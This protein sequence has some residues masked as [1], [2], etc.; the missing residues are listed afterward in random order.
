MV[1]RWTRSEL[2][3][4]VAEWRRQFRGDAV[5]KDDIDI[6]E[7]DH[8]KY[9]LILFGDT[10]SNA[11]MKSVVNQLPIEWTD[12]QISIGGQKFNAADHA[13]AMIYPNPLNPDRYIVLNS[14]FTYREYAYLNNARQVPKLPDWA[15]VDLKT[16]PDSLWPG[17]IV[18]ANFFD[19]RKKKK[20]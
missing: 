8:S 20:K 12:Q 2:E 7:D 19:E 11:V 1:D 4:F 3:H 17:K 18:D 15:I 14:G 6:T 10:A 5:V 16:P 13:P 9:H